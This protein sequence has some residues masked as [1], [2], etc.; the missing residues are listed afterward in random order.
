VKQAHDR[1]IKTFKPMKKLAL[2]NG[3]IQEDREVAALRLYENK[4][5]LA[6]IVKSKE[7]LAAI[8]ETFLNQNFDLYLTHEIMLDREKD[9]R[10]KLS[11][12]F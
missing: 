2:E 8:C 4:E 3:R 11:E 10:L 9:L 12:S 6:K 5:K 1:I 7:M